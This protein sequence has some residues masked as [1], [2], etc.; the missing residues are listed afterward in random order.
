MG[1]KD[2]NILDKVI[3][4]M[5]LRKVLPHIQKKDILLDFGCGYQA[6]LLRAVQDVVQQGIGVDYDA[7]SAAISDTISV[8]NF[9]FKSTLPFHDK[10]FSRITMLAVLEHIDPKLVPTLFSEFRRVLKPGGS[11]IVTTPTPFGK[12]ILE[13]LAFK[14]GIISRAEVRDHKK[15]YTKDDLEEI[16]KKTS[17]SLQD[18]STFQ[19]GGNCLAVFA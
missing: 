5:R 16:A 10:T 3:A 15:Y 12:R 9:Q 1:T 8:R 4:G 6:F 13:F 14:L 17:L 7:P 2:F 18:Y 19:L 11:I